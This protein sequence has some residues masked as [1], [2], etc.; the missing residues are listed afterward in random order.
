MS[1]NW[2]RGVPTR[3]TELRVRRHLR[4]NFWKVGT[5]GEEK[6]EVGMASGLVKD[7][8][9]GAFRDRRSLSAY[10]NPRSGIV[11]HG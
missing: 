3:S 10:I 9:G 7:I 6:K 1:F 4:K 2:G 8:R 5:C 11:G